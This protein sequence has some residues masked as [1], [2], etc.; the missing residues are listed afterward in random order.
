MGGDKTVFRDLG[1]PEDEAGALLLLGDLPTQIR[2]I[3]GQLGIPSRR[4]PARWYH[5][6]AHE[7]P[8]QQLHPQIHIGSLGEHCLKIGLRGKAIAKADYLIQRKSLRVI[9]GIVE[10]H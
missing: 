7:R 6:A 9:S 8:V 1:F 5:A 4:C 3:I 2:K 10:I